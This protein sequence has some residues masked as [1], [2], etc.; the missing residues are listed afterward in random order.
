M[1]YLYWMM[2][3]ASRIN[4]V[5]VCRV[6]GALSSEAV[7]KA[8]HAVQVSEPLLNVCIVPDRTHG[9]VFEYCEETPISFET[10]TLPEDPDTLV[11]YDSSLTARIEQEQRYDFNQAST[12]LLRCRL[13][14]H[15][16]NKAT[17]ILA[18]HHSI[19]DARSAFGIARRFMSALDDILAGSSPSFRGRDNIGPAE[20]HFPP[21]LT[22]V[23]AGLKMTGYAA[24]QGISKLFLRPVHVPV[25][26]KVW[27]DERRERFIL[28]VLD[29]D[30]TR[31]LV[32]AAK[33]NGCTVHALICAAQLCALLKEY[34]S[35]DAVRAYIL[36]LVDLR[37][38]LGVDGDAQSLNAMFSMVETCHRITCTSSLFE[39]A[40][41]LKTAMDKMIKKG[42]HLYYYP[43]MARV[44]R[45]TR[46]LYS[47]DPKGSQR[48]LRLGEIARPPVMSMSNVG[49]LD[50]EADFARFHLDDIY[51]V[52][53]LS[54]SGLFG[55]SANTFDNRLYWNFSY[56]EPSVSEERAVRIARN[57]IS[58]LSE[59][60]LENLGGEE[61][62]AIGD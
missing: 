50:I 49:R 8:L 61:S 37:Q 44:I 2:G 60:G 23:G 17:I 4:F 39:I 43:Q 21:R 38:R 36:S 7:S 20:Q 52:M 30:K 31:S 28:S 25:D 5:V 15:G 16:E 27:A 35:R 55:A 3:F 42:F 22:G 59:I 19:G 14:R 13:M 47:S 56:A 58:M 34:P 10:E 33:M 26:Q 41:E 62:F 48:L 9:A 54:S 12:P 6:T 11:Q 57:S 53:P 18:F 32:G 40:K 51:F 24:K 29:A 1:E 45:K 46:I